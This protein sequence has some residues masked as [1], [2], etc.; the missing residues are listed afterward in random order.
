MKKNGPYVEIEDFLHTLLCARY[1][2]PTKMCKKTY[3]A[4]ENNFELRAPPFFMMRREREE[5]RGEESSWGWI[6]R[7]VLGAQ[8]W[9]DG[10]ICQTI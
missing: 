9:I 5:R 6:V 3:C 8:D 4:A 10:Y 2:L 1:R 7:S